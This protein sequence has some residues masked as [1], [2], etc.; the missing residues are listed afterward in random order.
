MWRAALEGLL[1]LSL[2]P[3]AIRV[4]PCLP[5]H[6]PQARVTLRLDGR[7]VTLLLQRAELTVPW[8]ALPAAVGEWLPTAGWADGCTVCAVLEPSRAPQ[9]QA[10][11]GEGA[12]VVSEAGRPL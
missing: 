12:A 11:Q 5:A 7:S 3:G 1:G 10:P 9:A 8:N 6:W 2:R 4:Q